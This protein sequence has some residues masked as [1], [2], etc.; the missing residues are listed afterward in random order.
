VNYSE[1]QHIKG[2]G[3]H[4]H[5]HGA[6]EPALLDSERGIRTVKWSLV[7]MFV[8]ALLQVVVVAFTGSVALLADTIGVVA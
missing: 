2:K 5:T 4:G 3:E 7:A 8:T 6:I 1:D